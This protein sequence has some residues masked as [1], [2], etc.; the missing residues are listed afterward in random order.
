MESLSVAVAEATV[1]Q[2]QPFWPLINSVLWNFCS[3]GKH[4]V[5][6]GPH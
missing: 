1:K 2:L 4:E 6:L 5:V 3:Q